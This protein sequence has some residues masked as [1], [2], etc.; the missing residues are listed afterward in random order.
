MRTK[1]TYKHYCSI[2]V[3]LLI[4]CALFVNKTCSRRVGYFCDI[5]SHYRTI[6]LHSYVH[7]ITGI[8]I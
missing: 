2:P 3:C 7:P 6:L 5:L 8:H 1:F 4:L